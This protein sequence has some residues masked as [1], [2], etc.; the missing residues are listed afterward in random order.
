MNHFSEFSF[1][2][3]H[4]GGIF[5]FVRHVRLDSD[6]RKC[7]QT[8]MKQFN[9]SIFGW[10]YILR[11]I[12]NFKSNNVNDEPNKKKEAKSLWHILCVCIYSCVHFICKPD[13]REMFTLSI[14]CS[15]HCFPTAYIRRSPHI[16]CKYLRKSYIYWFNVISFRN[17]KM[18][19]IQRTHGINASGNGIKHNMC[20]FVSYPNEI[21]DKLKRAPVT[22][23]QLHGV[24]L[25]FTVAIIV[26]KFVTLDDL[27]NNFF[28]IFFLRIGK[29]ILFLMWPH[30]FCGLTIKIP[31]EKWNFYEFYFYGFK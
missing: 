18:Q 15:H 4:F 7:K 2:F 30:R 21:Y 3:F 14:R 5:H 28:F 19:N 27:L 23:K 13:Q 17:V 16:L 10:I 9:C 25:V 22:F 20:R 12:L 6:F 11:S 1:T 24:F 8:E 29:W 26:S 31:L